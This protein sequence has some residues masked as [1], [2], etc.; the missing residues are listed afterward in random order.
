MSDRK[1]GLALS[2]GGARG[3]AHVGVLRA[4]V[5]NDIPIDLIAGCS[6]G[7][8]VGG[9][10][11][12]GLTVDEI[13]EVGKKI[14]WFA[15]SGFS[16]SP[17]GVLTNAPLTKLIS[18]SF[19]ATRFEELKIPFAAVACDL[20][21]GTEVV[22]SE[23]GDMV[24]AIRASCAIPGV[25][26]PVE[27]SQGRALV[28][29]GVVTP[30]PTKTVRDMGADIV[31]A[32]DLLTSG[33]INWGRPNTLVGMFFQSAMMMLRT[34]SKNQH[35]RADIVIEPPIAHIRPDEI[36]KRDELIELGEQAAI[37]K[38]DEIR[39]LLESAQDRE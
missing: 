28:D 13:I 33:S 19:P 21:T 4:L 6:A 27:D 18:D 29:G 39:A 32:V 9:A 24:D 23:T 35:Y 25:F 8:F 3:F 5:A 30:M 15:V 11:A 34:A 14:S 12:A 10:Y 7:S 38:L 20:E 26:L 1:V 37:E 36:A 17:R 16:Y 22:L 2:G 31:I